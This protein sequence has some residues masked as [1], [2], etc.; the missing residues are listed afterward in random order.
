MRANACYSD[1]K[2]DHE[3]CIHDNKVRLEYGHELHVINALCKN[4]MVKSMPVVQGVLN[5]KLVT[6]LRDTHCSSARL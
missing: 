5:G 1:G 6:V 4:N 2:S 3:C